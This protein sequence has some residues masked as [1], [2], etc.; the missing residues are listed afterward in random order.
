MRNW[1]QPTDSQSD[2]RHL[3]CLLLALILCGFVATS[4][5][6]RKSRVSVSPVRGRVLYNGQ[7]VSPATVVFFPVDSGNENADKLRPFAYVESDGQFQLKTY[8]TG[9]GAPPGKYRVSIIAPSSVGTSKKDQPVDAKTP[10]GPAVRVPPE[11]AKKY[12]NVDTAGIEVNIH[13]GENNLEPFVLTLASGSGAHAE[14]SG[15][16][17]RISSTN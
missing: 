11:I 9:D 2:P 13:E 5:C 16:S 1:Q 10:A 6:G 17:S 8:V 12:A 4:G 3:R 15:G 14:T 7:G